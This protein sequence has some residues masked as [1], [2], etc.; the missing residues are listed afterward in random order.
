MKP[1][2]HRVRLIRPHTMSTTPDDQTPTATN[3]VSVPAATKR[4]LPTKTLPSDRL[5][6]DRQIAAALAFAAVADS[7]NGKA[8]SNQE[9]GDIVQPKKMAA[10]TIAMTNAFFCEVG[11][12][13]RQDDGS[14]IVSPELAAFFKAQHGLSPENAPDKLRPLFEKQWFA[15]V[16]GPRLKLGPQDIQTLIKS[17]GE[18]CNANKE[19]IERVQRL[20]EFLVYVGLARREGNQLFTPSASSMPDKPKT[21]EG[22]EKKNTTGE[23]DDMALEKYVLTLDPTAKRRII[24]QTPAKVSKAELDRIQ[25]WL[26][27]QLIVTDAEGT[28]N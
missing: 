28:P 10:A 25:K 15:Q 14:F 27:F 21:T 1:H 4:S 3:D 7:K 20:V 19:H 9:A 12:M 26:S 23:D 8:V 6:L 22:E 5:T 18:A 17:L 2:G 13:S 24:I 16:V 11:M